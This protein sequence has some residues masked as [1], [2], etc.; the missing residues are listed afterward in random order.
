[1]I[2]LALNSGPRF[3]VQAIHA[4]RLDE[5]TGPAFDVE[6]EVTCLAL[7]KLAGDL[8]MFAGVWQASGSKLAIYSV[9]ISSQTSTSPPVMLDL[10]SGKHHVP[11]PIYISGI[12]LILHIIMAVVAF[13]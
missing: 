6:G 10:Q 8:F 7:G 2:A 5:P 4:D 3:R 11:L 13:N 1:M 9:N 12:S